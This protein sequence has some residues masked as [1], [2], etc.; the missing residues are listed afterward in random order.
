MDFQL[1]NVHFHLQDGTLVQ[2][3]IEVAEGVIKDII[4]ENRSR[5]SALK[6]IDG[7]NGIVLPGFI[8]IHIHGGY[9]ADV[10]DGTPEALKKMADRLPS[11]GTTSFL[12][13]TITQSTDE[14]AKAVANVKSYMANREYGFAELLGIHL[15]GPYI[16]SE[17]AGAQNKKFIEKPSLSHL[18]KLFKGHLDNLEI[19]T[20]APELDDNFQMLDKLAKQNII[21]S[22]GHTS[23][24]NDLLK[25]AMNRGVTHLTHICNAMKGIHHRD[26][27]PVGTAILDKRLYIELIADGVHV[28]KEMLTLLYKCVGPDRIMLITDS[29]RAKG[30]IDGEYSLGGQIV[31]VTNKKATLKNGTLAGSVLKLNEALKIMR[32]ATGA[33]LYELEIMSSA[34]AAKR[35]GIWDRKGS[36][37][38]GKDADMVVL[39]SALDVE[40]TY[41]KGRL[42]YKK[43]N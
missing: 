14:I 25:E 2:G 26:M 40:M 12:A 17:Q 16:N 37:E 23:A 32:E 41:C 42:A 6:T 29:I 5:K 38:R 36:I 27:G 1:T 18:K 43:R 34:T 21:V 3:C 35:L 4:L 11:E 8:D 10:M 13:T 30:L 28:G 19:V 31:N 9:G 33:T 39:N 15:E 7:N 22:A 24:N 20:F